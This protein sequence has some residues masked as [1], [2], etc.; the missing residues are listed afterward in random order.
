MLITG[1]TGFIGSWLTLWLTN[2]GADV[3]GYSKNI[4]TNPSLFKKLKLEK[5]MVQYFGDVTDRRKLKNAVKR[6]D[7]EY[8]FHLAGQSIVL[9]SFKNPLETFHTNIIGTANLLDILKDEHGCR[10]VI[11][12]TSDKCYRNEDNKKYF[13]EN[14][15]LGGNDPYSSSKAGAE[16]ITNS[17]RKSFFDKMKFPGIATIRS[18]NVIGGGDWSEFRIVPDTIRSLN[19]KK[20]IS[21]RNPD[22][23][24][25]FQFVLEP[26]SAMLDLS[27]NLTKNP[28]KFSDAWN[29]GPYSRKMT[30]VQNLV[31]EIIKK[32]GSG[33]FRIEKEKKVKEAN[34]LLLNSE[35]IKN[36]LKWNSAYSTSEAIHQTIKWYKNDLV[37]NDN[38]QFSLNQINEY[39]LKAKNQ[40]IL[41]AV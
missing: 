13:K 33:S 7:P 17:Y 15:P 2:L 3:K 23:I 20:P 40:K 28:K 14:N 36:E 6:S 8:I 24:R 5:E 1:N 29:V 19:S 31:D 38:Y 22:A 4:P 27:L 25:P 32:W 34:I 26:I 37:S 10:S 11:I 35:K 16:L 30:N 39:I 12:F 9:N 18:G 21:I 41:W